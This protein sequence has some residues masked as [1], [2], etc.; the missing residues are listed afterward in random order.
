MRHFPGMKAILCLPLLFASCALADE[1]S[2]RAAIGRVI[3]S[4]N[5]RPSRAGSV[6]ESPVAT[7]E[8]NRLLILGISRVQASGLPTVTISHEP[9]GE[10][11]LNFPG[12]STLPATAGIVAGAMRFLTPEVA[13]VEA[14]WKSEEVTTVPKP[15]LFVMKKVGEDWK[16]A[17]ARV[18]AQR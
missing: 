1:A 5:E 13:L 11:T 8:L 16:I 6:G 12:I 15:L 9:W 14:E 2:D 10:A 3:A 7:A 4:L 17:S 18:L